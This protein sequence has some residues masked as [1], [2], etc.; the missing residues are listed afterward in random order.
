MQC[1]VSLLRRGASSEEA[2][3][4][5]CEAWSVALS[6][7]LDEAVKD[8]EHEVGVCVISRDHFSDLLSQEVEAL[9]EKRVAEEV[10]NVGGGVAV[11]EKREVAGPLCMREDLALLVDADLEPHLL[12]QLLHLI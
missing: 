10:V 1:D 4:I 8:P 2:S 3:S 7:L 6:G 11:T 12:H 5:D 9:S